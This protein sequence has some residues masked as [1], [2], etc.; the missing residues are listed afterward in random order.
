MV[1]SFQL[2]RSLYDP[3]FELVI[4]FLDFS[5]IGFPLRDVAESHHSAMHHAALVFQG[6][7][8]SLNPG[9]LGEP[10]IAQKYLGGAGLSVNRTY[11]GDFFGRPE[12]DTLLQIA[13]IMFRPLLCG[14]G[15]R[16]ATHKPL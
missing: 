7:T 6:T 15:L 16:A 2:G 8:A 13:A 5:L 11:H 14:E 12:S 3:M 10:W 9:T 1:G 4:E